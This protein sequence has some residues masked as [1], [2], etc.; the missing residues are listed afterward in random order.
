MRLRV[1]KLELRRSSFSFHASVS[2]EPFLPIYI[3]N[4]V[5]GL[6]ANLWKQYPNDDHSSCRRRYYPRDL[7]RSQ[8]R[9]RWWR[10][11]RMADQCHLSKSCDHHHH[12]SHMNACPNQEVYLRWRRAPKGRYPYIHH[13]LC[14]QSSPQS[15]TSHKQLVSSA[16]CEHWQRLCG[17]C[18]NLGKNTAILVTGINN[19][20]LS[21]IPSYER[22]K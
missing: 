8:L 20:E 15:S 4:T 12:D 16:L 17:F 21:S 10:L 18:H 14:S 13:V 22:R 7:H 1:V 19:I 11:V 6:L 2:F 5:S 3:T 9:R